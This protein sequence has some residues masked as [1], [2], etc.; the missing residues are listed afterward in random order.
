MTEF[1]LNLEAPLVLVVDSGG[2]LVYRGGEFV[3]VA[4]LEPYMQVW[5]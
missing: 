5:K 2:N 3:S 1:G 4:E